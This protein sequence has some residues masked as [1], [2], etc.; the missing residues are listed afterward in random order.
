MCVLIWLGGLIE[1]Y[2]YYTFLR[3]GVSTQ[4]KCVNIHT[5]DKVFI[6]HPFGKYFSYSFNQNADMKLNPEVVKA[7][8]NLTQ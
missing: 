8:E 3:V 4:Y 2:K 5:G 6:N 7:R 1:H